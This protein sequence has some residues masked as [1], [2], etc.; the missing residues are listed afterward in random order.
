MGGRRPFEWTWMYPHTES[1]SCTLICRLANQGLPTLHNVHDTLFVGLT[2]GALQASAYRFVF[3]GRHRACVVSEWPSSVLPSDCSAVDVGRACSW[4]QEAAECQGWAR[5][6][7]AATRFHQPTLP[8]PAA[9][10]ARSATSAFLDSE[11]RAPHLEIDVLHEQ[12]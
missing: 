4:K 8:A 12:S 3:E 2:G 6:P 11:N 5:T 9:N 7:P 1:P 10:A